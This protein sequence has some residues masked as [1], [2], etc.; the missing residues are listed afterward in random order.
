MSEKAIQLPKPVLTTEV[1]IAQLNSIITT[2]VFQ[3]SADDDVSHPTTAVD[4]KRPPKLKYLTLKRSSRSSFRGS[5][6]SDDLDGL[7]KSFDFGDDND[8]SAFVE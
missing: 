1:T 2:T 3:H 7:R 6:A 4:Q 8:D 5:L